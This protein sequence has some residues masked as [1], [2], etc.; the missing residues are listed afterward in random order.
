MKTWAPMM[1]ENL[2]IKD[3][4]AYEKVLNYYINSINT[5]NE[6]EKQQEDKIIKNV[7]KEVIVD[8]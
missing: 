1:I 5:D 8:K 6:E 3:E 7:L 2:E 4:K